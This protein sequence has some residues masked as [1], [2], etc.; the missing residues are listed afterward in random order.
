MTTTTSPASPA[1]K[2]ALLR[3]PPTPNMEL[4][5]LFDDNSAS[6]HTITHSLNLER[7]VCT[8][9]AF[10][11]AP[12]AV[13]QLAPRQRGT[14]ALPPQTCEFTLQV[15]DLT[16][17]WSN[18][19][20]ECSPTQTYSPWSHPST[21]T[22]SCASPQGRGTSTV[23][24]DYS[25]PLHRSSCEEAHNLRQP[26]EMNIFF[27]KSST[28]SNASRSNTEGAEEQKQEGIGSRRSSPQKKRSKIWVLRGEGGRTQ[29]Q[30]RV[31]VALAQFVRHNHRRGQ[32]WFEQQHIVE[33]TLAK[34][35]CKR[36]TSH[37]D[38]NGCKRWLTKGRF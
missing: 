30:R 25:K 9:R 1:S 31:E 13:L 2:H 20:A 15:F 33:N 12:R 34:A 37:D 23:Y 8:Q 4:E 29:N 7:Q 10:L 19:V 5:D 27:C 26:S 6:S 22:S 36:N 24:F 3:V 11:Q 14:A 32:I 16:Q 21:S 28:K 18:A 38:Q 35:A 17:G